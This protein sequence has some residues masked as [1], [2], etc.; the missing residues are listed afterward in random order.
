MLLKTL[1]YPE[2]NGVQSELLHSSS[3]WDRGMVRNTLVNAGGQKT[4]A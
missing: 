3:L 4:S 2:Q 1:C